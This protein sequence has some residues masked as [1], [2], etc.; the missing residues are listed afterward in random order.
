MSVSPF[1]PGDKARR[2]SGAE[3]PADGP[4][5]GVYRHGDAEVVRTRQTVCTS[6]ASRRSSMSVKV[7]RLAAMGIVIGLLGAGGAGYA[8]A[9]SGSD[10]PSTTSPSGSGGQGHST[11]NCPNMGPSTSGTSSSSEM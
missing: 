4:S 3:R 2:L 10:T 8:Y 1:V 6:V 9:Q 11:A 5:Q 7:G